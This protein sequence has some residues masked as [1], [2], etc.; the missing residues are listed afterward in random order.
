MKTKM[1]TLLMVLI[2]FLS[3]STFADNSHSNNATTTT[4][5]TYLGPPAVNHETP[6]RVAGD[7]MPYF[8]SFKRTIKNIGDNT[9]PPWWS[10]PEKV[11]NKALEK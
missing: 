9:R 2:F 5:A 3:A 6:R 10:Y 4:S 11:E 7:I 1:T 8:D